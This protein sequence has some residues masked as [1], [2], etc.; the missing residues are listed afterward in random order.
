[1]EVVDTYVVDQVEKHDTAPQ[2]KLANYQLARD[3][4]RRNRRDNPTYVFFADL[5]V[6]ALIAA[7]DVQGTEAESYKEVLLSKDNVKWM[8]AMTEEM[9]SVYQNK[10]WKLGP[11][12]EN[13]K[14]V[15]CRWLYK[16]KQYLVNLPG[17]KIDWWP[18]DTP[19]GKVFTSLRYFLML[20]N[21]KLSR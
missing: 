8:E 14:L 9:E 19:K 15:N 16:K 13:T 10:T 4:E 3:G 1:M 17:T 6:T 2:D 21:L 7:Q 11:K 18:R 20:L 5:I 12:L